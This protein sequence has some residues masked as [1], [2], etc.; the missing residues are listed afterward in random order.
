MKTPINRDAFYKSFKPQI[1]GGIPVNEDGTPKDSNVLP[2]GEFVE[3]PSFFAQVIDYDFD[4]YI[5]KTREGAEYRLHRD[6]L[7]SAR[8]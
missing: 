8:E 6:L 5:I 1:I 3:V 4:H 7:K 2:L